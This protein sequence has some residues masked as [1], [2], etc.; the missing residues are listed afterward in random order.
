ML[1][2]STPSYSLHFLVF[3]E[4]DLYCFPVNASILYSFCISA[5]SGLQ[6]QLHYSSLSLQLRKLGDF[7]SLSHKPRIPRLCLS[8]KQLFS[9][10][11]IGGPSFRAQQFDNQPARYIAQLTI[12]PPSFTRNREPSPDPRILSIS[13]NRRS[14]LYLP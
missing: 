3:S 5:P 9:L 7:V 8:I 4:C 1:F 2:D 12:P 14:T 13:Y 6:K 11:P 10:L